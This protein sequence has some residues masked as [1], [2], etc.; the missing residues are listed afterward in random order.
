MAERWFL[1]PSAGAPQ[2]CRKCGREIPKQAPAGASGRGYY[3]PNLRAWECL[4]CRASAA[5]AQQPTETE[6]KP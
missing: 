1:V 5:P 2:R 6:A 3:E 4:S